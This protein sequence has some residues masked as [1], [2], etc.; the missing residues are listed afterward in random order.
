MNEVGVRELKARASEI[1]RAV[2]DQRARYLITYRGRPVGALVPLDTAAPIEVTREATEAWGELIRLGEQ[3]GRGWNSPM[4][5]TEVLS[6]S[7]R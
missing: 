6:S 7:R 5:S 1:I 3:I 2:R 4:S